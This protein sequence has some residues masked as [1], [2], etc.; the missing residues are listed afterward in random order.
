MKTNFIY[1]CRRCTAIAQGR[2]VTFIGA[3]IETGVPQA[4]L[5]DSL[6]FVPAKLPVTGTQ[7]LLMVHR[8][9]GATEDIYGV[10]DLIGCK[11]GL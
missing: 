9:G 8:C 7:P 2:P 11:K 1:Q 10:A 6:R 4:V 3:S 5:E